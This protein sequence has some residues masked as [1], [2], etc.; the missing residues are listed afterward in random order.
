LAFAPPLEVLD[1]TRDEYAIEELGLLLDECSP[2][3]VVY[4]VGVNELDWS[5]AVER[6][7]FDRIMATNVWGFMN[8]LKGLQLT[9]KPYS[10]L[11][12]TSDA[13]VRPMRTSMAYCASKAALDMV[14]R[15]ASRELAAEGWRVNGLAPGKVVG[16][17]MTEYVDERVP[18]IRGWARSWA[19]K[20]ELSS[21]PI[22]RHLSTTEVA[23]VACDVL[24]S[25]VKGWTGDIITVN[26]GR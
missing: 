20:Y 19:T 2:D 7:S 15:V 10:V 14:I 3:S 9:S 4:S 6:K 23:S 5:W 16:T 18:E 13:A 1:V 17:A 21:S 22:G 26:G 24:L 11:A 25:D 12:I 8:V